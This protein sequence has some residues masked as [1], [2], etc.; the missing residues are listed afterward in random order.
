[1]GYWSVVGV[2]CIGPDVVGT[3][4]VDVARTH[5]PVAVAGADEPPCLRAE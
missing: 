2:G 4:R 3:A 5:R 1:M